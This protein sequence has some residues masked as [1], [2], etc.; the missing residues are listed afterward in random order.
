M[1][2]N[3]TSLF[4]NPTVDALNMQSVF[5]KRWNEQQSNIEKYKKYCKSFDKGGILLLKYELEE[6]LPKACFVEDDTDDVKWLR[7]IKTITDFHELYINYDHTKH[8]MMC[9][10]IT[11]I[12]DDKHKEYNQLVRLNYDAV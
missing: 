6:E 12:H 8:Y 11:S 2:S 5:T 7:L 3:A 1:N 4:T 10:I 9:M